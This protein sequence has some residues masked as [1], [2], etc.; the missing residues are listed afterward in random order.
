MDPPSEGKGGCLF[1]VIRVTT[2]RKSLRFCSRMK[3]APHLAVGSLD[4]KDAKR[5]VPRA[6][7]VHKRSGKYTT[8][9]A[10]KCQENRSSKGTE[11]EE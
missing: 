4:K 2:A 11:T 5:L 1:V 10:S 7:V 8:D 3:R 9:N 6:G